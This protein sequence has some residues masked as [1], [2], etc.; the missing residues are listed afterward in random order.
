M[1]F[2][3]RVVE[4]VS[5][6]EYPGTRCGGEST[7]CGCYGR[8][9]PGRF[10]AFEPTQQRPISTV[11]GVREHHHLRL[12]NTVGLPRVVTAFVLLLLL[13]DVG[14]IDARIGEHLRLR[15]LVPQ[16]AVLRGRRR[17]RRIRYLATPRPFQCWRQPRDEIVNA[18][19]HL[20]RYRQHLVLQ[21]DKYFLISRSNIFF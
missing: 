6:K 7:Q 3:I 15:H 21:S 19:H 11:P 18:H 12:G 2:K 5:A 13:V 17:R 9:K 8:A 16:R 14:E 10:G 1:S 4:G 20:L